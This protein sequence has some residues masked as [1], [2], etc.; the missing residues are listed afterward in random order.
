LPDPEEIRA[1]ALLDAAAYFADRASRLTSG[2]A[3]DQLA[4][5]LAARCPHI[6]GEAAV[7]GDPQT[8]A[9]IAYEQVAAVLSFGELPGREVNRDGRK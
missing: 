9:R 4:A 7:Y 2:E 6:S 1:T 5:E 8:L 3:G